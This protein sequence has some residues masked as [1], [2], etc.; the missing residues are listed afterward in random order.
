VFLKEKISKKLVFMRVSRDLQTR[1]P[2]F[3]L[4]LRKLMVVDYRI[5]ENQLSKSKAFKVA[6]LSRS[7]YYK[8]K[9]D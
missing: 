5:A 3:A 4:S 1:L 6:G 2:S 9:V 8:P 7:A